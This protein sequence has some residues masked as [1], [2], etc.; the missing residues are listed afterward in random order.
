MTNVLQDRTITVVEMDR[1]YSSL[2]E[3]HLL[4][5]RRLMLDAA[6]SCEPPTLVVDL[7]QTRYFGSAFMEVLFRAWHRVKNRG[8]RMLLCGL[9]AN[10][11]EALRVC[12]LDNL[13]PNFS[14][15][16]EAVSFALT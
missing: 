6:A 16:S 11:Q 3:S 12:Q 14:T 1:E 7:S 5:A 9:D 2:A 4:D 15:R 10:G 13:W 8:G